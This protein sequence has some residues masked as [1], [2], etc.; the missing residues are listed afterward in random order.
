[1]NA[2]FKDLLR[3]GSFISEVASENTSLKIFLNPASDSQAFK[4]KLAERIDIGIKL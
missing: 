3:F 1:M 2:E 4:K